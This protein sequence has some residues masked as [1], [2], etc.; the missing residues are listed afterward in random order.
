MLR[1]LHGLGDAVQFIRY[2]PLLKETCRTLTVQSHPALVRLLSC[3][4][5]VDRAATWGEAED[6]WDVQ[7]EVT[8]L[9]RIF[10]TDLDTVPAQVPYIFIPRAAKE[11]AKGLM[12]GP[13]SLRVGSYGE[14]AIGMR[15]APS[16]HRTSSLF[17]QRPA[18]AFMF[19]RKMRT[20]V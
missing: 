15:A 11:W 7:M 20:A 14:R 2:A 3:V 4:P 17:S 10:R 13:P 19:Y 9:P 5:S 16:A 6:E 18:A 1:C 8:E 12:E